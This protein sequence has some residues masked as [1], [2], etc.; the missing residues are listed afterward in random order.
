MED[1]F[2]IP[3]NYQGTELEFEAKLLLQGYV[4]RV[5]V[6]VDGVP[7]LF[8]PD[9][10]RNYR[11]LITEEQLKGKGEN[12]NKEVLQAIAERLQNLRDIKD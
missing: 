7:V 11:A 6:I 8:E 3:V 12:L 2:T 9:E 5:E 1:Y 10:E 4:H